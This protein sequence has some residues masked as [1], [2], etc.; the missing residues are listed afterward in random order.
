MTSDPTVTRFAPSPTGYLHLGH[1]RSALEGWW[2]ARGGGGRFLL[3][4]EDIDQNRCRDEYAAAIIEDLVWLG[5]SWDGPVRRQSE[6][7]DDYLRALDRLEAMAVVYPCFCT[8]REIR[9][10]IAHAGGAPHAQSGPPYPGTCPGLRGA[11]THREAVLWDRL[12][13]AARP[14][15]GACSDW[16]DR[17][18]R[19]GRRRAASEVSG[20]PLRSV[21]SCLP[22]R[23]C[24]RAITS[25]L[26][27]TTRS[28]GL[29]S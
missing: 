5:L 17:V 29:R 10:E 22:A 14:R 3:R 15:S 9:D 16:P 7:F 21:M 12:C 27:P 2:A 13:V 24:R 8:R 4:L 20:I 11:T 6:H 25:P 1:V 18:G 26:P 28:K 19:G 23:T